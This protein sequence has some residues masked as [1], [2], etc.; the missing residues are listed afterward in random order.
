MNTFASGFSKEDGQMI[1]RGDSFV[2]DLM[3]VTEAARFLTV[4][5][6]TFIRLVRAGE[7]PSYRIGKRSIRFR[8]GDLEGFLDR[9]NG[10]TEQ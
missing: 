1:S 3:T 10:G 8:R 9:R 7:I 4:S 2:S 6:S 5:E